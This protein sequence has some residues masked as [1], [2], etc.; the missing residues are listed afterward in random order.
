MRK[1]RGSSAWHIAMAHQARIVFIA[2]R[3]ST[4]AGM[5]GT[6]RSCARTRNKRKSMRLMSD[7]GGRRAARNN[8]ARAR[9]HIS[10]A[11]RQLK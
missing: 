9:K 3:G 6:L 8:G 1:N 7:G 10:I 5:E 2:S 4:V 11:P